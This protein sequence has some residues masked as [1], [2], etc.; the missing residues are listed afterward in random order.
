MPRDC[1]MR[2]DIR[3]ALI[4][5]AIRTAKRLARWQESYLPREHRDPALADIARWSDSASGRAVESIL[6]RVLRPM[7]LTG[8]AC[9]SAFMIG[10]YF[11][12]SVS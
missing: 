6:F 10:T 12:I 7:L 9:W 2:H 5:G 11:M 1:R 8:F 3:Q 4:T